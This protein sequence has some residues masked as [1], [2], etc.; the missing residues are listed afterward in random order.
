MT[1]IAP[2]AMF[3]P[4]TVS[5][6]VIS[7]SVLLL[8]GPRA[9]LLQLAHP[10]VA[11]GVDDYSDFEADPFGRLR[12]TLDAMETISFG[13]R[14][15]A[16]GV[17]ARLG[18]VHDAVAGELPGGEAYAAND[19][20]LLFWVHATLVDTVL[21]VERR[22]LGRLDGDERAAFYD[23]SRRLA[24]AFGVPDDLVPPDLPAFEAWMDELF[25][26]LE[27]SD[28]ARRLSRSILWPRIPLVPRPFWEP[29]R[30]VTVD[31]LPRPIREGYGLAWDGRRKRV[32][33]SS[34][35]V[36]RAVLPRL[37]DLVRNFPHHARRA[38]AG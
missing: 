33:R 28:V 21:E 8:G 11:A 20:A 31:M 1:R 35:A 4:D 27:V 16:A 13:T 25:H 2:D 9:L 30:M 32:V 22:Y 18:R 37:P 5:A 24:A 26:S 3:G 12:R 29:L 17:L 38:L 7:E 10:K 6:S 34:Q 14:D 19:P 15:E 23:E 36:V